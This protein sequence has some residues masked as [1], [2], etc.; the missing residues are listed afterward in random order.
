MIYDDL[1]FKPG[2]KIKIPLKVI[3]ATLKSDARTCKIYELV[4]TAA[5]FAAPTPYLNKLI[6][7]YFRAQGV[8]N[9]PFR[10]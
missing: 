4:M 3:N 1:Y 5:S 8:R 6:P 7:I 10:S 9:G 2:Y